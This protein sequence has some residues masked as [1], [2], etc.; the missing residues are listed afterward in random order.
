MRFRPVDRP[1]PSWPGCRCGA[2]DRGRERGDG[3][4]VDLWRSAALIAL[5]ALPGA[6][7]GCASTAAP[8][9][10]AT[11]RW[12]TPAPPAASTTAAP[13]ADPPL[14]RPTLHLSIT[15][16]GLAALLDALVDRRDSGSFALLGARTWS[17]ERSPFALALD[18]AQKSIAV[19][20]DVRATVAVPGATLTV[21][22]RVQASV[23]P[24]LST[25][26]RLV[27]QAVQVRVASDD[28][29]VRFAD[30]VAGLV[31]HVE[32]A[33]RERLTSLQVDLAPAWQGLATQLSTPIP[34]PLPGASACFA[35]DVRAVEAGPTILAD[36]LEKQLALTIAPSLT[37]PCASAPARSDDGN[38]AATTS[39]PP[40]QNA[41]AIE[42]G[43][44][45][46]QVPVAAAYDE[47]G[48]AAQGAFPGGRLHFSSEHPGLFA[49]DPAVF[50]ADG[51][52]VVRV[53]LGGFVQ[54]VVAGHGRVDIDGDLYVTGRPVV[55]DNFIEV[56][57]LRPTLESEQTLL[58]L[59]LAVK[60]DVLVQALHRAL[61]L[62]LS[63]RLAGARAKLV[64][65]LTVR[66]TLV[67]GVGPLC[68]RVDLGRL[69]VD[70]L[71][72]HDPYLRA[73]VS[74]TARLSAQL[75][76]PGS[77]A[78]VTRP[79]IDAVGTA[80]PTGAAPMQPAPTDTAP[81]DTATAGNAPTTRPAPTPTEPTPTAPTPTEPT[82]ATTGTTVTPP[83][84]GE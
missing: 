61:R 7:V 57:E 29:R 8:A 24:V 38:A 73:M 14:Q 10:P 25:Q 50:A 58:R 13:L 67:E 71:A 4:I 76:C 12:T 49:S 32:T 41:S 37:L 5:V 56:A 6:A 81:T 3:R 27:L 52:L 40:L 15:R 23:Q 69:A 54:G 33:L 35:L 63:A 55:R 68:T 2:G 53:H 39:L 60:H 42:G 44:F 62:D 17:W 84:P 74:T 79:A 83:S 19:T 43:P 34:L 22:L 16:E 51:A 59:A 47:L 78:V 75:P 11:A 80:T 18:D 70:E 65:A 31:G 64:D 82:T 26:H 46:L 48:R 36:G 77:A 20:T 28:R 45:R 66:R 72:V 21:P 1:A 9:P 30:V